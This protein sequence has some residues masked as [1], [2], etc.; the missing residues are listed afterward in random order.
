MY[1][2]EPRQRMF[3]ICIGIGYT[4][5]M[6]SLYVVFIFPSVGSIFNLYHIETVN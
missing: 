1:K 5:Y 3:Y 6:R 2:L 4:T